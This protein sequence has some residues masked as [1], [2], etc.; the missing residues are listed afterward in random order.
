MN[1]LVKPAF[2]SNGL[3]SL[4]LLAL[5][6]PVAAAS[7]CN[8]GSSAGGAASDAAA[9]TAEV[10][11]PSPGDA[12]AAPVPVSPGGT[13]AF[14]VVTTGGKQKLYMPT[15]MT[16]DGGDALLAVVDV[17][18]AGQ[19]VAGAPALLRTIDLG[20]TN[21]ATTTG[22]DATM[23]VAA[24]GGSRD[25]WFID[26]TTDTLVDHVM[27]DA[28]FGQA[29]FSRGG[30]YVTGIAVDSAR[31]R[32]ILGVWNGFAL[33]DLATHAIT[34]VIQAPPSENF[35][36][37]SV[38]GLLYAPF[39]DCT[40]SSNPGADASTPSAC[41]TP[42]TPGDAST[43]MT[44]GLSVVRLSDGAVF[45]YEDPA[46]SDPTRPVGAE[47][48]SAGA[49][50]T[51]QLVAV[52]SEAGDFQNV[53]DFSKA[54]FDETSHT[55]TAPHH[56]LPGVSYEGVAVDPANHLAFLEAEGSPGIAVL[57]L[58]EVSS[59]GQGWVGGTMPDLPSGGGGFA[60]LGDPDGI[61]VTASILDG[62]AVG[63]LVDSS[64]HWVARVDLLAFASA[65]QPDASVTADGGQVAAAVTYL[66][67]T[68]IE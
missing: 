20:T 33:V 41:G 27:L 47:P 62:K 15:T 21:G 32:A 63:F 53:L 22:G 8:C 59:G 68:T 19:G 46:A 49:D 51:T 1:H 14:G 60:N 38:H 10:D 12:D 65:G 45:T 67:V 29:G 52:P 43:V 56:V 31:H 7:G 34:S 28:S 58:P 2:V 23:I 5:V 37:D 17:G 44:D 40:F 55:V 61:A 16:A 54:T 39:Y 9:D 48:D 25:V 24:A 57:S 11:G 64:L 66:D 35:G 36:F 50:P 13:G 26:P 3:R 6:L 4:V 42:M 18:V 30:G